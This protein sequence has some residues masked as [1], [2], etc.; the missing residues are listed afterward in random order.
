MLAKG[1][2]S[3]AT[4]VPA[5]QALRMATL[6][7]AIALGG[8]KDFGSLEVGKQADFIA[9]DLGGVDQQPLYNVIS[10]LVRRR[11]GGRGA[12][13]PRVQPPAPSLR[14]PCAQVYSCNRS[15]VT[16]VWVGGQQLM[17][18]RRLT[19]MDEAAVLRDLA[20]WAAKVRPGATAADKTAVLP[21]EVAAK[22]LHKHKSEHHVEDA[23][24][25][26]AAGAGTIE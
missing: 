15:C 1:V 22:H 9:L 3:D 6:N 10:A 5:W 11:P 24:D 20:A 12:T 23:A 7:G 2:A 16:D 17:S 26:A 8:A 21:A 13:P 4:A 25:E 19:T 14:V 18:G